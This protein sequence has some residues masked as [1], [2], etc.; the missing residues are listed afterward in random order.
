M[1]KMRL[2]DKNLEFEMPKIA[3]WVLEFR[4]IKNNFKF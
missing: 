4:E 2:N 1:S 3:V